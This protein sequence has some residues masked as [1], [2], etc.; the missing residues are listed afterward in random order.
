LLVLFIVR[1]STFTMIHS[2]RI[3][4]AV[5]ILALL[6]TAALGQ[7][8]TTTPFPIT[9]VTAPFGNATT[10]ATNRTLAPV[11]STLAP[12]T[13]RTNRAIVQ[14]T[15][16]V[17][18]SS[19]AAILSA[20][21]RRAS[22][23][24]ATRTDIAG[25]AQISIDDITVD[26]MRVGSLVA[27]FTIYDTATRPA[28]DILASLVAASQNSTWISTIRLVYSQVS[29]EVITVEYM[30]AYSLVTLQPTRLPTAPPLA[31][32]PSTATTLPL[33]IVV[34]FTALVALFAIW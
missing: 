11:T 34:V 32:S 7:N 14:G 29:T 6:S 12:M 19:F 8:V 23:Q 28:G 20:D 26:S 25:V 18:G 2:A 15:L 30:T 4:L 3:V 24:M 33:S 5:A 27:E 17:S 10:N 9:N 31:S 16:K 21:T 22:L 13:T 1:Q